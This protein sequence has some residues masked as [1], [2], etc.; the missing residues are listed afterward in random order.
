MSKFF[1]YIA[2]VRFECM[3]MFCKLVLMFESFYVV[4]MALGF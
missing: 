2:F 3:F 1:K 4:S